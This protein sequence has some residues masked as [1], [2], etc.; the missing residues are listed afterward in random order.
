MAFPLIGSIAA[1][2]GSAISAISAL[3]SAISSFATSVAPVIG[4]IIDTIKPL[5]DTLGRF[6]NM[7]LT[8]MGILRP[9]EKVEDIGERA[10]QA[11]EQGIKP[12]KFERFDQY[13]DALRD[14]DLDPDKATQRSSAAK[15]LAGIGVCTLGL[16][17]KLNYER[18]AL[19]SLWVLPIANPEYFTPDRMQNLV[20]AG[21]FAGDAIAYLEKRLSGV[22]ALR[23]EKGFEAS[24]GENAPDSAKAALY[25]NLDKAQATWQDIESKVKDEAPSQA[26]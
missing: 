5:A 14:F 17:D 15:I 19:N 22:D 7:F 12:E 3:G 4:P 11:S 20:N 10:M 21:N 1:G 13:M 8:V 24:L 18:G 9:N 16:E 25:E 26:I 6:A 23:M 2:I